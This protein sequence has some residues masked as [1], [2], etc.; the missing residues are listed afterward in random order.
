MYGSWGSGK[1]SKKT[2]TSSSG[3]ESSLFGG[4]DRLIWDYPLIKSD[5]NINIELDPEL[6]RSKGVFLGEKL[7]KIFL[8]KCKA[9]SGAMAY[10]YDSS[11]REKKT[12]ILGQEKDY[13]RIPFDHTIIDYLVNRSKE[14]APLFEHY[15]EQLVNCSI[16]MEIPEGG[17]GGEGND[18][19]ED[20]ENKEGDGEG[21]GNGKGE[22]KGD[23]DSN[24]GDGNGDDNEGD[25]EGDG[26]DEEDGDGD[27]DGEGKNQPVSRG[28]S[29]WGSAEK[30]LEKLK[31]SIDEMKEQKSYSPW[32]SFSGDS[33]P[34]F[35][36]VP[37][38]NGSDYE[39]T[40]EEK[41]NA[42]LLLKKLDIS[43]DPKS[44]VVKNLKLGKLDPAKI[45]EVPAGNGSIY[46][47][48]L[49]DQDTKPFAVCVL[50][51]M[52]G[53]ME[54]TRLDTQFKVLNS[55]YLALSEIIPAEDLHIYGHTGGSIEP[56][57]Y[58][59]CNPYHTEY[60]KNIRQYY[61][62]NNNSNY[63][64]VV[65]EAIH[66]KIRERTDNPVLLI[67]ISDGQPCDDID[68]MKKILER[69]RRDQFV[70]IGIGIDTDYVKE[71]YNYSR[72][73]KGSELY[74]MPDEV[75]AIL[76]NVV[77]TEFK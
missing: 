17:G 41:K 7:V 21:K 50:A 59:F 42:E 49:E 30:A 65:I 68:N 18:E 25:G 16:G 52:S 47:Q 35:E 67:T 69:A 55:L 60:G 4:H 1:K 24:E 38:Y 72:F 37:V 46:K 34:K 57:I 32:R 23:G 6:R 74:K 26:D 22:G 62:I 76:N 3:W 29:G 64:G 5:N 12:N 66:K 14:F 61:G 15:R 27:G 28:S 10:L 20:Q 45:A 73:V 19:N 2:W 75:S 58:T 33:K 44:D 9:D 63:D 54:G 48:T 31:K 51:D 11:V 36:A 70:T 39:F 43:F 8:M 56:E 40:P 13:V 77:R 71:L 53:S